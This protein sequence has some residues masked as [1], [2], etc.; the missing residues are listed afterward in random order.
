[1][2]IDVGI[3]GATGIVGQ[4]LIRMIERHPWFEVKWVAASER[5][6]GKSYVDATAWRMTTPMP[7]AVRN[8]R[9]DDCAPT[10]APKLVF[11]ALDA[12]PAKEIEP[13]FANLGH[14]V[15]SNASAFRMTDDVPL[16]LPEIN[17]DHA[18]LAE[19]QAARGWKG[20]IYTNGNCSAITLT[21]ALAPIE[22]AFGLKNV[23]VTTMQAISGAG[24]P[25]VPSMDILGNVIPY[26][27]NEEEKLE[28]ETQRILGIYSDGKVIPGSFGMSAQCNRVP[29][30]D[31]HTQ[32]VSVELVKKASLDEMR[33]AWNAFRGVPQERGLPSAPAQPVVFRDEIDRPQPRLDVERGGG[34]TVFVGRAR[35]CPIL[36]YK[37][38]AL[39]HNT[40]RGA[41]GAALLNAELVKS[42]NKL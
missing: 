41:A 42:N 33:E 7:D 30:L 3:L 26:I 38:V 5:S 10:N 1:M 25:G 16:L 29:V 23:I 31:G 28:E 36:D 9:V 14:I 32:C 15:V 24:Y 6:V 35:K 21:L 40:V 27:K 39:G 8:L 18:Q 13:A 22:R 37:F 34:M 4:H 17:A 12:G 2:K 20:R 19:K 11:S